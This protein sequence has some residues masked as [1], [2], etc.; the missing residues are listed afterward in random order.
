MGCALA[1]RLNRVFYDTD[2]EI[3]AREQR[4]I[5]QIVA[6]RDWSYFRRLEEKCL[7][8]LARQA[9]IVASTGGGI[10]LNPANIDHMQNSGTIIWLTARPETILAR[11]SRDPAT[12]DSRPALTRQATDREIITTLE[13]RQGLYRQAADL[14]V[15]TDDDGPDEIVEKILSLI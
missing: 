13:A 15:A 9:S 6:D 11:L 7:Q 4:S 2:V 8:D 12:A 10:V 3:T 1:G 5:A 14:V